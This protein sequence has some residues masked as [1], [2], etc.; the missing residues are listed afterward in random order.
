VANPSKLFLAERPAQTP[1]SAVVCCIE[2]SRPILVEVQA[3]VSTST[4]GNARRMAIGIDQNRLSLLL[5]VLEKR[6][7]LNLVGEDVFVNVAGGLSI[8][9]P[10]VDLGLIAAV[11]SSARNRPVRPNTA[12]FGEWGWPGVRGLRSGPGCEAAD[13]SPRVSPGNL[14]P[15]TGADGAAVGVTPRRGARRTV[16]VVGRGCC[17]PAPCPSRFSRRLESANGLVHFRADAFI[18]LCP[19][20]GMS[21]PWGGP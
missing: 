11:G 5:A 8:D 16:R 4:Y 1:G 2:G 15:A 21:S 17:G 20:S 14:D 3:L 9:E 7:G 12:V 19:T 6:A 18:G 10:A 13:G